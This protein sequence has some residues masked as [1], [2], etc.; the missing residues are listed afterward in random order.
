MIKY[1]VDWID[2][3]W[4]SEAFINNFRGPVVPG[5]RVYVRNFFC[6]NL[7]KYNNLSG[8]VSIEF[9]KSGD[10]HISLSNRNSGCSRSLCCY[11]LVINLYLIGL[12]IRPDEI[13]KPLLVKRNWINFWIT[14]MRGGGESIH[15][16]RLNTTLSLWRRRSLNLT[17]GSKIN[18]CINRLPIQPFQY[19]LHAAKE[20]RLYLQATVLMGWPL[21]NVMAW[22]P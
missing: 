14:F 4:R 21:L 16:I 11:R 2:K 19:K 18:G 6:N 20:K 8:K 3:N 7:Y 10:I 1:G 17:N 13:R 15:Y 5:G 12:D 22:G 9:L